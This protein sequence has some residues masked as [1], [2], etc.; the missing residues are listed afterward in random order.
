MKRRLIGTLIV[1]FSALI[2]PS[3]AVAQAPAP[4]RYTLR[5][6][7]PQTNYLEVEAVVPTDGHPSVEMFMAVWTPGSYLVREYERNVEA[8][9]ATAGGRALEVDK[10]VK[11]R[12]RVTTNGA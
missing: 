3:S 10:P 2:A 12:W 11:N 6:P 7:A 4:I 8:V 9:A 5:F 1:V